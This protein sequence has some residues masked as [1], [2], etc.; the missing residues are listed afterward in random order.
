M[1]T[2]VVRAKFVFVEENERDVLYLL[3]WFVDG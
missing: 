3:L 2:F 1:L